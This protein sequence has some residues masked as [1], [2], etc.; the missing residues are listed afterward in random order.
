MSLTNEQQKL[1]LKIAND[2]I[3]YGLTH[4]EALTVNVKNYPE[5]LQG[6]RATFVTLEI[7]G[8]LRGCIGMLEAVQP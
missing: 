2:S 3:A 7:G 1:L 8:Q 5:E 4:G 6:I